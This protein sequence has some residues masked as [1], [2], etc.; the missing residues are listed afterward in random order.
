MSLI[1]PTALIASGATIA[2][3]VKIGPYCVVGEGVVLAPRVELVSHVVV[4]GMTTIGEGT[5]IFPFAS[6]G[7]APQDLKYRGEVS[8][9]MIG[10]DCTI[11]EHVTI[12]TGTQGG[13]MV[14]E[15]GDRVLLAIGAH[16]AHDCVIGNNVLIMNHVLLGGHVTLG[17]FC[18]LG[19]GSAVHQFVRVGKHAMVG[20]LSGVENDVIPFGTV[21]GNRA[22]L[23]GLNIVG[24]RRRGFSREDI[25]AVRAAY[26]LLFDGDSDVLFADR[27]TEAATVWPE[28]ASVQEVVEF[29][30]AESLRGIC[31]P[32][33]GATLEPVP[34]V[35]D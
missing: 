22:R 13:G 31:R 32:V 33:S 17:D 18:I 25:H 7:L 16:V 10:R 4:D 5:R 3:G 8:S 2:P 12:N 9:L 27:I 29:L 28:S 11:R 19:G 20:G 21:T 15:V 23:E 24:L 14:T 30:R 6:I 26:R 1:H 34:G 35:D